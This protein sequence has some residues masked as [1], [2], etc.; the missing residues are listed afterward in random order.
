MAIT[1]ASA[2]KRDVLLQDT[3]V[4][5]KRRIIPVLKLSHVARDQPLEGTNKIQVPYFPLATGTSTTYNG[6]NGYDTAQSYAVSA[7]EVTIA[8]RKYQMIDLT[9]DNYNRLPYSTNR[10][11]MIAH[12][13]KLADDVISDV[14]SVVTA[15]NYAGT[16]LAAMA[17]SAFDFDDVLTLR[18]Y[19]NEAYFPKSGRILGL[20]STFSEYL[21]RDTRTGN[22]NYDSPDQV[23]EGE[24]MR[25]GGFDH[26]EIANL[27]ANGAE[28]IAGFAAVPSAI[29][30]GFSP[31]R[32]APGLERVVEYQAITDPESGLTLEYRRFADPVKDKVFEVVE[33]NYGYAVGEPAALKRIT[34]P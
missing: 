6:T 28:K 20:D 17:A 34:T 11:I 4:A 23:R 7:K 2:L 25:I 27:P 33:C 9:S 22:Q 14:F 1:T 29:V 16:T 10:E 12:A 5:F 21:L 13:E 31:I 3:L 24:V 32:L 18:R 26:I 30:V 19:C 8:T 15:A